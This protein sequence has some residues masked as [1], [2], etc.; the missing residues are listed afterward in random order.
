MSTNDDSADEQS[1]Q[2]MGSHE[3]AGSA[4][5]LIQSPMAPTSPGSESSQHDI[6]LSEIGSTEPSAVATARRAAQR[7]AVL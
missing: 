4:N 3:S 2:S 6:S 1:V 5:G 7:R